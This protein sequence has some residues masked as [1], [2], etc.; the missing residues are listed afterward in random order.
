M[1]NTVIPSCWFGEKIN[2]PQ[3]INSIYTLKI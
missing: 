1:D 3:K 2:K